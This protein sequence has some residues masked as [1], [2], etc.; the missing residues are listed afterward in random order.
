MDEIAKCSD[1]QNWDLDKIIQ[2]VGMMYPVIVYTVCRYY[3]ETLRPEEL[4]TEYQSF[5]IDGYFSCKSK[6]AGRNNDIYIHAAF[7]LSYTRGGDG[8]YLCDRDK[9][10]IMDVILSSTVEANLEIRSENMKMI[11]DIQ[12]NFH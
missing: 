4:I 8:Y 2:S 12:F 3:S 6:F 7:P 9:E 1:I 11:T 5:I 10:L